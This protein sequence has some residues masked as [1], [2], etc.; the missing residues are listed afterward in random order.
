MGKFRTQIEH[1][2]SNSTLTEIEKVDILE[3]V[4][5]KNGKLKESMRP[6]KTANL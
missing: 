5:E 3:R 4:Q 6:S 2:L 1:T